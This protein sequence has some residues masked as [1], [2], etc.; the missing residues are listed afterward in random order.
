M[1]GSAARGSAGGWREVLRG[2]L[3]VGGGKCCEGTS[4]LVGVGGKDAGGGWWRLMV[5]G[6]G[7]R[8]AGGE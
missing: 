4:V 1:E 5:S 6:V 8:D 3:L 2:T 7:G